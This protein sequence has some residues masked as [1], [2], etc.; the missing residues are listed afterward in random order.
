MVTTG[1]H[2][3]DHFATLPSEQRPHLTV[4]GVGALTTLLPVLRSHPTENGSV[5]T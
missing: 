3:A 5:P 2:T 1:I 4:E